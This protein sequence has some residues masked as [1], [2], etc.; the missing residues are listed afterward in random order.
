MSAGYRKAQIRRLSQV[1]AAKE[2]RPL[3]G[4]IMTFGPEDM[5]PLHALHNDLLVVQLKITT[6][7]V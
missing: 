3:S 4:P 1:M 2:L 5:H 7:M 6:A